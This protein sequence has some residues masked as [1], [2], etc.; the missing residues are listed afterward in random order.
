MAKVLG[1]SGGTGF[2]GKEIIKR[3][4]QKNINVVSYQ[5]SWEKKV[6][7]TVREFSLENVS[8][9]D[10]SL[11]DGV[12]TFVHSAALVHNKGESEK[13]HTLNFLATKMLFKKCAEAGVKKF[14]FLSTVG[15]YGLTSALKSVNIKS[16][17][18]PR[19]FYS[20]SKLDAENYLLEK[21]SLYGVEVL[22]LRLPLV[23]GE[24][25]PG[26]LG[27]LKKIANWQ[28]P[29]P[30]KDVGNKRSII[31]VETLANVVTDCALDKVKW[32]GIEL[33]TDPQPLSTESI[34]LKFSQDWGR[35]VLLFSVPKK[36]MKLI[37]VIVGKRIIYEKLFE[38]LVF[39]SSRSV[40]SFIEK[41][42]K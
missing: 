39:E 4:I 41:G 3:S 29:L 25:A 17:L 33:I 10:V 9:M 13:Y 42:L 23:C 21:S 11:L 32:E 8:K 18:A 2:C 31:S 24:E 38:D 15:V 35:S 16:E 1:I 14:I 30:F 22:I 37:F 28:I 6:D 19:T 20:K 7:Y 34:I 5:R 27:L 26:N 40:S 12:D 36:I